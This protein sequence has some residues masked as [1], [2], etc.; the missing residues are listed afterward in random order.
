MYLIS[1]DISSD[2]IR[3]KIAKKLEDYGTRVQYSVFEC[4]LTKSRFK[5]LYAEL[6]EIF[7]QEED[8]TIRIYPL[9]SGV[10]KR[11]RIIGTPG[12]GD[13]FGSDEVVF[14]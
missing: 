10:K 11:M 9:D 13:V 4:E 6:I 12:P 5:K 14:I 1:Y 8:G 3:N 7:N 2:R